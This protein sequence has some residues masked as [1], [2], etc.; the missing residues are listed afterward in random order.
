MVK[1]VI[2]FCKFVVQNQTSFLKTFI[3]ANLIKFVYLQLIKLVSLKLFG[4]SVKDSFIF[5]TLVIQSFSTSYSKK[6][7]YALI[8]DNL[9][10]NVK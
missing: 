3:K 7:F 1:F 8:I 2:K 6:K 9:K 10:T 4:R 5:L